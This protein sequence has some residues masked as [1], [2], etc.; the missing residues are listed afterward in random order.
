[1]PQGENGS[2][3]HIPENRDRTRA[4]KGH[5][6]ASSCRTPGAKAEMRILRV[7]PRHT[8]PED[9]AQSRQKRAEGVAG[10][11]QKGHLQQS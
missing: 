3:D 11:I 10:E 4:T 2:A 9:H 6:P 5:P 1:M 7:P 8:A